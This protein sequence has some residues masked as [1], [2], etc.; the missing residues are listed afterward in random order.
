MAIFSLVFIARSCLSFLNSVRRARAISARS[1]RDHQTAIV[2]V[3]QRE[4]RQVSP[5][6]RC[7]GIGYFLLSTYNFY[8]LIHCLRLTELTIN[9][10]Y[11]IHHQAS[12]LVSIFT[13]DRSFAHRT[14]RI[15]AVYRRIFEDSRQSRRER[16]GPHDR[17]LSDRK[18]RSF[19][20]GRELVPGGRHRG[21]NTG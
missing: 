21:G 10:M 1:Y 16:I 7:S 15:S 5:T 20:G 4:N 17:G 13:V 3:R 11:L 8:T 2:A 18:S 6:S 9:V 14:H 12:Y 19:R